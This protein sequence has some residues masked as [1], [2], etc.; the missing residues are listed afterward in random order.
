MKTLILFC[1]LSA[2]IFTHTEA[3]SDQTTLPQAIEIAAP[4]FSRSGVFNI[5]WEISESEY[6]EFFNPVYLIFRK[7][8]DEQYTL[9]GSTTSRYYEEVGLYTGT[10]IYDIFTC[11]WG[12]VAPEIS[13]SVEVNPN[14]PQPPDPITITPNYQDDIIQSYTYSWEETE[15]TSYYKIEVEDFENAI[16][17]PVTTQI[18]TSYTADFLRYRVKSCNETGCGES[19]ILDFRIPYPC[20]D[21]PFCSHTSD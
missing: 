17:E 4:E 21:Y 9:V 2:V 18:G 14:A 19:T 3:K 1:F 6:T 8:N 12:C 20:T 11:L 10:Y 15:D 16:W 7:Q 13:H 5:T